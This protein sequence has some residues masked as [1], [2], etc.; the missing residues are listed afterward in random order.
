[1]TTQLTLDDPSSAKRKK[2]KDL[3]SKLAD[4][5]YIGLHPTKFFETSLNITGANSRPQPFVCNRRIHYGGRICI[6]FDMLNKLDDNTLGCVFAHELAHLKKKHSVKILPA[7]TPVVAVFVYSIV[8]KSYPFILLLL[9]VAIMVLVSRAISWYQEFEAD[10]LAAKWVGKED[11]LYTLKT[12]EKI[13]NRHGDTL[14]HPSFGKRI[15]HLT[16]EK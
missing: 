9:S 11:M 3:L 14:T 13:M 7:F 16:G 4:Q 8:S 6:S 5:N 2:A 10:A 15:S 1:M 12:I